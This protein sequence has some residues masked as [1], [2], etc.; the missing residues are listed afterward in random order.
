MVASSSDSRVE[1]TAR[2][3]TG[4]RRSAR[5]LREHYAIERGLARR[6]LH[7][8]S[9]ERTAL[10]VDVYDELFRRIPHHPQLRRRDSAE[11]RAQVERELLL[12]APLLSTES[13]F[14]ELGAGDLALSAR[15]ARLG[16]EVHAVDVSVEIAGSRPGERV[17]NLHTHLTDGR[18]LSLT[19]ACVD[20]AYSN[21]LMEHLHPDDAAAQLREIVRVLRPGGAYLCVTPNRLSGPWDISRMFSATPTGLHLRE[22]TYGELTA[23]FARA[24]FD[25]CTA[26]LPLA[27]RARRL[28]CTPLI[29]AEGA[30]AALPSGVRRAAVR[31]PLGKPLNSV[32]L[33]ARKPG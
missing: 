19:D 30:L 20:V 10:Y 18:E 15:V 33:L 32:R 26:L 1:R 2:R 27:G 7:A 11:R 9:A 31:S 5:E 3:W 23:L 28:R 16:A 12:L 24:G 21:Q 6:L 14:L 25:R 17:P 13:V 8:S 29:A 22:Y 4:D